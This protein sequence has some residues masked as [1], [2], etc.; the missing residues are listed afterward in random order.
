MAGAWNKKPEIYRTVTHSTGN[1]RYNCYEFQ[2]NVSPVSR[3]TERSV[4]YFG[5]EKPHVQAP[6]SRGVGVSLS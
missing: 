5:S 3:G 2:F 6:A 1:A 4:R